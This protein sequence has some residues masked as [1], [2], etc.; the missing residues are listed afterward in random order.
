MNIKYYA[1][2][3]FKESEVMDIRSSLEICTQNE[4]SKKKVCSVICVTKKKICTVVWLKIKE[5]EIE[6]YEKCKRIF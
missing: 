2:G 3:V 4:K 1:S 6:N 5:K